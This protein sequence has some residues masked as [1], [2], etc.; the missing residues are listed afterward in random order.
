MLGLTRLLAGPSV[1]SAR[2]D[3]GLAVDH[4]A[5]GD[6]PVQPPIEVD[7]AVAATVPAPHVVVG[8]DQRE[9]ASWP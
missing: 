6:D 3:A 7:E 5:V 1:L 4:R 2:L 8:V 9:E